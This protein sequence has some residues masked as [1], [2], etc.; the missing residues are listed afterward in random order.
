MTLHPTAPV[1]LP[2]PGRQTTRPDV[3]PS[4]SAFDL[5]LPLPLAVHRSDATLQPRRLGEAGSAIV[6]GGGH[7]EDT[8]ST[9]SESGGSSS[10]TGTGSSSGGTAIAGEGSAGGSSAGGSGAGEDGSSSADV[11]HVDPN[12]EYHGDVVTW[13]DKNMQVGRMFPSG[14][15]HRMIRVIRMIRMTTR[16]V[17]QLVTQPV[18]DHVPDHV[19]PGALQ[20]PLRSASLILCMRSRG[21]QRG[22]VAADGPGR[23]G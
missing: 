16:S 6:L 20:R 23:P 8:T 18:P 13:G 11:C 21:A 9:G 5:S 10:G 15:S 12:N 7:V 17:T 14:W 19:N 3:F 2:G 1:P 22:E 4:Y